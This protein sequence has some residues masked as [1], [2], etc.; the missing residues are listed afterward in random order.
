MKGSGFDLFL[1]PLNDLP[2]GVP[3]RFDVEEMCHQHSYADGNTC[4]CYRQ[5]SYW[6]RDYGNRKDSLKL[7]NF[8]LIR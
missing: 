4:R 2:A 8:L 1:K 3:S 6:P 7:G 5:R